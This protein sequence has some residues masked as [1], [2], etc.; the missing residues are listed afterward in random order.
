MHYSHKTRGTM[1]TRPATTAELCGNLG[2]RI[3]S[4]LV[5]VAL[6]SLAAFTACVLL[7]LDSNYGLHLVFGR[8]DPSG[9]TR[10]QLHHAPVWSIAGGTAVQCIGGPWYKR[11][12]GKAMWYKLGLLLQL[13]YDVILKALMGFSS[14][15][16]PVSMQFQPDFT[17]V[18]ALVYA[19]CFGV[20]VYRCFPGPAQPAKQVQVYTDQECRDI[21]WSQIC[22]HAGWAPFN[23]ALRGRG[24]KGIQYPPAKLPKPRKKALTGLAAM[25]TA[26]FTAKVAADN[27]ASEGL[28]SGAGVT[29]GKPPPGLSTH[30]VLPRSPAASTSNDITA[31][32]G[33]SPK[34][35]PP[36][37]CLPSL[38]PLS[39]PSHPPQQPSVVLPASVSLA[40]T[41]TPPVGAPV[42]PKRQ[43]L[44]TKAGQIGQI[45]PTPAGVPSKVGDL[46][47][48]LHR[49]TGMT[50]SASSTSVSTISTVCSAVPLP[51][52][53]LATKADPIGQIK[54]KEGT[55]A[56][57]PIPVDVFFAMS[58][59]L[60]T[61]PAVH[62]PG[63]PRRQLSATT[64]GHM[65]HN[66]ETKEGSIG[67][68]P[69]PVNVPAGATTTVNCT[70][71][72]R[73]SSIK[74]KYGELKA[75]LAELTT[76]VKAKT[77]K[78]NRRS[79]SPASA[80]DPVAQSPGPTRT[81]LVRG[82]SWKAAAK[83]V[84][85]GLTHKTTG[86]AVVK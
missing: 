82:S 81:T 3:W 33:A 1:P 50:Q 25:Y 8:L 26:A 28:G 27:A 44:A 73:S 40:T 77:L 76:K 18:Y 41:P 55:N 7:W 6:L 11:Q 48:S 66:I 86:R 74:G 42:P 58:P 61:T 79:L 47:A 24:P 37:H 72:K 12:V 19:I 62:V 51:T 29:V 84:K 15:F 57:E 38:P 14:C 85:R 70:L 64:A 68:E 9:I 46:I 10:S 2:R 31:A 75:H 23:R 36:M 21:C 30:L 54:T 5:A 22:T 67:E 59:P 63:P 60:S 13:P 49:Q 34:P 43:L 52:Q 45:E 20:H 32:P 69:I 35:P 65:A 53:V 4:A 80:V 39:S 83:A 56:Q 78:M 71:A 17:A 16:N